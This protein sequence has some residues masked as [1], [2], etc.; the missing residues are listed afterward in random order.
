MMW[1]IKRDLINKDVPTKKYKML[2]DIPFK[3]EKVKKL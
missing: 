2:Y 3:Y 1:H